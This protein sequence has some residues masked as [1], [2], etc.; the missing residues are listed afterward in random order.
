MARPQDEREAVRRAYVTQRLPLER[1]AEA[2]SVPVSTARRWKSDADA[3]GDDWD[4]A[5]TMASLTTAGGSAIA[6]IVLADYLIQHQA[7]L[8]ELKSSKEIV[9]ID[10]VKAI[11]SLADAYQ[12]TINATSRARPEMA[13]LAVASEFMQLFSDYIREKYPQHAAVFLEVMPG[14]GAVIAEKFGDAS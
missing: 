11:A 9:L 4:R 7:V 14:F 8:E 1:A 6:E 5:R 3:A 10:R 2:A 13:K 12:K